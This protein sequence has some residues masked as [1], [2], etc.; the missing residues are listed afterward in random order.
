MECKIIFTGKVNNNFERSSQ[1]AILARLFSG[2]VEKAEKVL[3]IGKPVVIKKLNNK[4]EAATL[5]QKL[6]AVGLDTTAKIEQAEA[7]NNGEADNSAELENVKAELHQ[8]KQ[9][10]AQ[11]QSRFLSL[12]E[13]IEKYVHK[14][15]IDDVFES[16]LDSLLDN[17]EET[18][19]ISATSFDLNEE[20]AEIE[21]KP[22]KV[23]PYDSSD[24]LYVEP[25]PSLIMRVL[26]LLIAVLIMAAI[27]L[28]AWYFLLR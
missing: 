21:E 15:E 5:V 16:E 13:F 17:D 25:E 8:V 1:I 2:S 3:A 10:L 12:S 11:L 18:V 20:Q 28:S 26:P 23:N 7:S 6:R 24:D 22:K 4:Q 19:Q 9:E 14:T 27:G